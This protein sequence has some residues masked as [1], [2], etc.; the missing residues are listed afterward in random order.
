MVHSVAKYCPICAQI[1]PK[2]RTQRMKLLE[3]LEQQLEHGGTPYIPTKEIAQHLGCKVETARAHIC[4]VRKALREEESDLSISRKV[5][6]GYR[7][8]KP[9]EDQ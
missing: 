2:A 9:G 4:I 5:G 8:H 1:L 7:L 3:V 6:V